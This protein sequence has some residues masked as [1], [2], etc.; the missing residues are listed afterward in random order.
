MRFQDYLLRARECDAEAE[1]AVSEDVRLS[2]MSLAA[3]WR[4]LAW[5]GVNKA[6]DFVPLL[7]DWPGGP[8]REPREDEPREGERRQGD[9]LDPT[10]DPPSPRRG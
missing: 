5:T 7:G 8:R 4:R 3:Q 9:E 10:L 2:L 6:P 1:K